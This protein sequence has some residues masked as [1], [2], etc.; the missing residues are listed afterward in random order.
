MMMITGIQEHQEVS[1][2]Q[3]NCIWNVLVYLLSGHS[4]QY[5]T[6]LI[7]TRGHILLTHEILLLLPGIATHY[8]LQM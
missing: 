6:A 5:N 3:M 8:M 1:R 4:G 2:Q 7:G